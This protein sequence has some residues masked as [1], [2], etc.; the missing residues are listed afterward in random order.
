MDEL[1][2]MIEEV[3]APTDEES[4]DNAEISEPLLEEQDYSEELRTLNGEFPDVSLDESSERYRE[5]RALGL[6]P[7]EAYFA[8]AQ[9]T[10]KFDTRSHLTSSVP[11]MARSPMG[12]MSRRELEEARELF[13]GMSDRQIEDLYR[14]V[15]K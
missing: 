7:K 12:A 5:L 4:Y 9:R 11:R 13:S 15:T 6:T 2:E 14:K 10:P 8:S 3:E 1:E